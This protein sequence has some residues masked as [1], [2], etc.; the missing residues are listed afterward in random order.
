MHAISITDRFC[1]RASGEEID[2][3]YARTFC[4][5]ANWYM[6]HVHSALKDVLSL[7]Q[8]AVKIVCSSEVKEIDSDD[9][10]DVTLVSNV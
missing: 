5:S 1:A 7:K 9:C 6:H 2:T 3:M 10:V 4:T 8:C